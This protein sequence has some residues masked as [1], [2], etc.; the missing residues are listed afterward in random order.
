MFSLVCYI[1]Y[2]EEEVWKTLEAAEAAA[3][4]EGISARDRCTRQPA[5][6]VARN[7]KFLL[8]PRQ[9]EMSFA[10]SATLTRRKTDSSLIL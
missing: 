9:A 2:L 10:K 5:L 7:A 8:S 4:S 1:K 6:S 3:D